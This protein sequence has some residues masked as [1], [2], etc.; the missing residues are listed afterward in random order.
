[1]LASV[2]DSWKS[3][4]SDSV[5]RPVFPERPTIKHIGISRQQNRKK[6]Y[7]SSHIVHYV[8]C[9]PPAILIFG[10]PTW[11]PELASCTRSHMSASKEY[12]PSLLMSLPHPCHSMHN[13]IHLLI[14][15]LFINICSRW[16]CVYQHSSHICVTIPCSQVKGIVPC[17][18]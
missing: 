18:E 8:V 16:S 14:T 12:L 2:S 17:H 11:P 1:M 4:Q 5:I 13:L 6:W 7:L 9:I 15:C 3:K 10:T